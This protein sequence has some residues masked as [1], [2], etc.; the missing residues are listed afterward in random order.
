MLATGE[1]IIILCPARHLHF[2]RHCQNTI[3]ARAFPILPFPIR[4]T[5]DNCCACGEPGTP[6]HYATKC[7]SAAS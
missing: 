4:K 2:P 7:P 6:L 5:P 1:G 3:R